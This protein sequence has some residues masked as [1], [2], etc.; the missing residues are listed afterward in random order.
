MLET[1]QAL[2]EWL[3]QAL[4]TDQAISLTA[5]KND[6]SFRRYYRVQQGTNSRVVMDR[7]H[8][9]YWPLDSMCRRFWRLICRKA[10]YC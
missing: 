2:R 8:S 4:N 5:L 6:A 10:S 9:A 7:S 3:S 1:T